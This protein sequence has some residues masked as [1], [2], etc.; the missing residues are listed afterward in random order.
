MYDEYN[1]RAVF[2]RDARVTKHWGF[3]AL[4]AAWIHA[5]YFKLLNH[6]HSNA[7]SLLD[8]LEA[9]L[10]DVLDLVSYKTKECSLFS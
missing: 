1:A 10:G 2:T 8:S 5:R 6:A 9:N 4:K 7:Q 3:K